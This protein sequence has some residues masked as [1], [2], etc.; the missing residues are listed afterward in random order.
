MNLS[1][2]SH[3]IVSRAAWLTARQAL[4][5]QEKELTRKRDELAAQR[6][7]LPWVKIEK[8]Y[9]FEG[10]Q[11]RETL[12]D[13]FAG[14]EQ[15]I[16]YHFMFGP[17]WEE[18][19]KSCSFGMDHIDGMLL[20][21]AA[22]DT[23]FVAVSRASIAELQAFQNRMGWKFHWVSAKET[24]FN[25]DFH[26]SYSREDMEAGRVNYNFQNFPPG[27]MPVEELPGISV[28]VR[29]ASTQE[30]FH[31][32][33]AYARGCEDLLGTYRLLD[34]TPKGRDEDN[35]AHA[36]SWVRHHDRYDRDY[37]VDATAGYEPPRGA[38]SRPCCSGN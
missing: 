24:D 34:L 23:S 11:G 19:C 17:G 10:P 35:L 29:N 15:L 13:L 36:M 1:S 30:I 32:Y 16:V 12:G 26:V 33:S 3:P 20:H 28:F 14:R 22:R 27:L 37:R 18:G 31:S 6:R 7:K 25:A 21:L 4:L 9:R 2:S 5:V 8:N 38:I